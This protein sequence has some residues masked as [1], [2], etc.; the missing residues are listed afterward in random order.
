M[1]LLLIGLTITPPALA[2]PESSGGG[3]AVACFE[4]PAIVEDIRRNPDRILP[5]EHVARI[6]KVEVLDLHEADPAKILPLGEGEK[7]AEYVARVRARF[8]Q[9]LPD[10]YH[11]IGDG[12]KMLPSDRVIMEPHGVI[13]LADTGTLAAPL[14]AECLLITMGSHFYGEGPGIIDV[15]HPI[16]WGTAFL[17][18]DRRLFFHPRHSRLSRAILELHE[19]VYLVA[20]REGAGDSAAARRLVRALVAKGPDATTDRVAELARAVRPDARGADYR[21]HVELEL[22]RAIEFL[23]S[24]AADEA[25]ALAWMRKAYRETI[26]LPPP[27]EGMEPETVTPVAA[28]IRALPTLAPEGA[29]FLE[30]SVEAILPVLARRISRGTRY[31]VPIRLADLAVR[32]I[33]RAYR[34]RFGHPLGR[35]LL[36]GG[37]P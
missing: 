20:R 19:Y 7:P 3:N 1:V 16:D 5:D 18:V 26:V 4:S 6:T 35:M 30:T 33:D 22:A 14:P 34:V 25:D 37:A 9:A 31:L 2:G 8:E 29:A 36:P 11:L 21:S 12:M 27:V 24:A 17:H 15:Y 32:E 13:Q 28:D 23:V 10:V